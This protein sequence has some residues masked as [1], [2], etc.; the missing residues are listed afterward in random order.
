M[1]LQQI[2]E[3]VRFA[4]CGRRTLT[5]NGDNGSST[6]QYLQSKRLYSIG[7]CVCCL[8]CL[9]LLC[10]SNKLIINAYYSID[11]LA[12]YRH[13]VFGFCF[14][15]IERSVHHHLSEKEWFEHI[16][17]G[18]SNRWHLQHNWLYDD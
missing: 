13:S 8:Y 9:A 5:T 6:L 10:V 7:S 4:R 15:F 17:N 1:I 3:C 14:L 12:M 11:S 2:A 18:L 16:P